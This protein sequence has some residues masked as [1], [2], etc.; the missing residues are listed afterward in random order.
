MLICS[1]ERQEKLFG[2][3]K[4][5]RRMQTKTLFTQNDYTEWKDI[6]LEGK[7]LIR[8]VNSYPEDFRDAKYQLVLAIGGFGCKPGAIGN[9]IFVSECHNDE[10]IRFRM[11]R[12]NDEILGIAT[13]EAVKQWK[14]LYGEFN[15]KVNK[16][17]KED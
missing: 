3:S 12:C 2:K 5:D 8:E 6:D 9:A 13:D 4:G 11:E 14:L 10:P 16:Y 7:L 15:E 17:F 1:V